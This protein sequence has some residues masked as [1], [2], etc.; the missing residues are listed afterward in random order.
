MDYTQND[1]ISDFSWDITFKYGW[2]LEKTSAIEYLTMLKNNHY[3]FRFVTI[4]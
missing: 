1:K 3:E 4:K 2:H